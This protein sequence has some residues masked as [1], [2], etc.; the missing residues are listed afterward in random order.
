MSGTPANI[1]VVEDNDVSIE[2]LFGHPDVAR[3]YM[4]MTNFPVNV[5]TDGDPM[6]VVMRDYSSLKQYMGQLLSLRKKFET[7]NEA[8]TADDNVFKNVCV[9]YLRQS[10]AFRME[11]SAACVPPD[12]KRS[13][14]RLRLCLGI[15][16]SDFENNNFSRESVGDAAGR[17]NGQSSGGS[18][19]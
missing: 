12:V 5:T 19:E 16:L 9:D 3:H 15:S 11:W 8:A 7:V 17:G 13:T 2:D 18:N 14:I 10:N 4:G 1:V 6:V